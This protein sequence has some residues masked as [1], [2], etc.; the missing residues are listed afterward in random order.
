MHFNLT[1]LVLRGELD[2]TQRG[3]TRLT[4]WLVDLDSPLHLE[5]QGD[6]LYD[7]AGRSISFSCPPPAANEHEALPRALSRQLLQQICT[8]TYLP[9][10]DAM[11]TPADSPSGH[12]LFIEFFISNKIYYK[13]ETTPTNLEQ[14]P[15]MWESSE[16]KTQAQ[17]MLNKMA[18]QDYLRLQAIVFL[19]PGLAYA[20]EDF[21]FCAWDFTLNRVEVLTNFIDFVCRKY[22]DSP[23]PD[24]D[25]AF[26]LGLPTPLEKM[27][28]SEE[29]S[30]GKVKY[31]TQKWCTADLLSDEEQRFMHYV[32]NNPLY[33]SFGKIASII[34]RYL[35]PV[36]ERFDDQKEGELLVEHYLG[37]LSNVQ[38]TILL[39]YKDKI[40]VPDVTKRISL[41]IRH[42]RE[43][44][45]RAACLPD[46]AKSRLIQ[47]TDEAIRDLSDYARMLEQ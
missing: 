34:G 16:S 8:E 2:N 19:R 33:S 3:I 18:M 15:P 22:A 7:I 4:L 41:I 14:R 31:N 46:P 17:L 37:V 45:R 23:R 11:L 13:I 36:D 10:G 27:A 44:K 12:K 25:I 9:L 26:A 39:T 30:P 38:G 32:L 35:L 42:L 20:G 43:N 28:A 29:L 1:P 47:A 5:L 24:L 6:C 21:P 40:P